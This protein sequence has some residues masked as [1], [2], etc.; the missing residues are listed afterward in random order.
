MDASGQGQSSHQPHRRDGLP[1]V[2]DST[3][4]HQPS[5]EK[6][7]QMEELTHKQ[8]QE[9]LKFT[10]EHNINQQKD[11]HLQNLRD[12]KTSH[13]H[14]AET[15]RQQ[16]HHNQQLDYQKIQENLNQKY[17]RKLQDFYQK[18]IQE[19]L[20]LNYNHAVEN[21]KL[22]HEQQNLLPHEQQDQLES[23]QYLHKQ[24]QQYVYELFQEDFARQ[25]RHQIRK[26]GIRLKPSYV[27]EYVHS[28]VQKSAIE[29]HQKYNAGQLL[30]I[31]LS[32]V[33]TKAWIKYTHDFLEKQA[34]E[35]GTNSSHYRYLKDILQGQLANYAFRDEGPST[36][37]V[38]DEERKSQAYQD[39]IPQLC[40]EL[41]NALKL[42]KNSENFYRKWYY[43]CSKY[44]SN[45][46]K[47]ENELLCEILYHYSHDL[48]IQYTLIEKYRCSIDKHVKN[49]QE[50]LNTYASMNE[51][52]QQKYSPH[53]EQAKLLLKQYKD[54]QEQCRPFQEQ[55]RLFQERYDSANMDDH[56]LIRMTQECYE[57]YQQEFN[58]IKQILDKNRDKLDFI[59][60]QLN[61]DLSRVTWKMFSKA[62]D[63]FLAEYAK[64][65]GT[66]SSN[67]KYLR[68]ISQG[69][70]AT[71]VYHDEGPSTPP[72]SD[73]ERESEAYKHLKS[74]YR[75]GCIKYLVEDLLPGIGL[76]QVQTESCAD[77]DEYIQDQSKKRYGFESYLYK[78]AV[79]LS[80]GL[81]VNLV[82]NDGRTY[83]ERLGP[84]FRSWKQ[85]WHRKK[86]EELLKINLSTLKPNMLQHVH[87]QIID[88]YKDKYGVESPQY[89]YA[90]DISQGGIS[91]LVQD[92]ARKNKAYQQ[93]LSQFRQRMNTLLQDPYCERWEQKKAEFRQ[94]N[95]K[96]KQD[97]QE[98]KMQYEEIKR[99]MNDRVAQH[100]REWQQ[101]TKER[102]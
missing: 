44:D 24:I 82:P 88:E 70:T 36:P 25:L 63:A 6:E 57:L 7:K 76:S 3:E 49:L 16:Q 91:N 11:F 47:Q 2:S 12:L 98:L 79:D 34:Q 32:G 29:G 89:T 71:H 10:H 50:R 92:A 28:F 4:L 42:Q 60:K 65:Y 27:I 80:R 13:T 46:D 100:V 21:L 77:L 87:K 33:S 84:D 43:K 67:Y 58:R 72:V 51:Y 23:L 78:K 52:F 62:S 39:L 99:K 101:Q 17:Y 30:G 56:A 31:D 93:V 5:L 102:E 38:S 64:L 22:H 18:I 26:N 97:L 85:E 90:V 48:S 59:G 14:L 66:E 40:D 69:G 83:I 20:D 53:Q 95:D 8:E 15:S 35:Y 9:K 61:L 55:C 94:K 74:L 19:R 81:T 41:D 45:H 86:E 75:I 68:D 1:S 37:P 54:A 96:M 73:E